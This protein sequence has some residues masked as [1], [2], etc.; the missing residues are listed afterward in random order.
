MAVLEALAM[1]QYADG[2]PRKAGFLGIYTDGDQWCAFIKDNTGQCKL[3]VRALT[4]DGM[5]D[6]LAILLEAEDA[7]WEPDDLADRVKARRKKE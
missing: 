3:P 5:M 2:T 7:P 4:F 1:L 6:A